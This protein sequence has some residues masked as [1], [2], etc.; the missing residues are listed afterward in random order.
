MTDEP[1]RKRL[2]AVM[3]LL[4]AA[5]L[6]VAIYLLDVAL[7]PN[8]AYQDYDEKAECRR[9][10]KSYPHIAPWLDSICGNGALRDTFIVN[11][12]VRLHAYLLPAR[13]DTTATALVIHG[14][15]DCALRMLHIAYLYHHDLGYNVVLPDLYAHGASRGNYIRMGWL[16][17]FDALRWASVADS[18]FG[19]GTQMVVHGISMGAATVMMMSGE[20]LPPCV[21]AFVE[22]C[23]YTSVRDEFRSELKVRYGLPAFPVLYVAGGLCRLVYGWS[24][25]EASALRQ[26]ARCHRPMLFIHGS[27]DTFVPTWMVR[28]LY[29]AKPGKKRLWLA[30]GSAHAQAYADHTDEYTRQVRRFLQDVASCATQRCTAGQAR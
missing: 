5:L 7:A 27:N 8:P 11:R 16:D 17:R 1:M 6:A 3:A 13:R 4:A 2:F 10:A 20:S 19:G 22:D 29:E 9:M 23:G 25:G 15:K 21:R 14:Y 18:T 26:V 12:G 30:P 24:F 28:P